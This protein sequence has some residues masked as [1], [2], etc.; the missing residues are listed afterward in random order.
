MN[1][2]VIAEM[3]ANHCGDKDLAFKIIKAAKECGADAI[4][5]Q[6]YTADTITIDCRDLPRS[7][8]PK[9]NQQ[10]SNSLHIVR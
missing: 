3:S 8:L 2:F 1:P 6:T 4:K 10:I 9:M 5:V 7:A